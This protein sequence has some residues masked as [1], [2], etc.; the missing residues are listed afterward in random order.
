METL[1]KVSLL[2]LEVARSNIEAQNY[3]Q[4]RDEIKN[5][6]SL[7][8]YTITFINNSGKGDKKKLFKILDLSLRRDISALEVLRYELPGKYSDD[9]SLVYE[10]VR[11][12][13]NLALGGHFGKDF[14]PTEDK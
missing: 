14:F 12:V 5:Y 7:I 2:R 11:K 13:R 4:A 9:A 3:E 6:G 10:R 1:L 8:D